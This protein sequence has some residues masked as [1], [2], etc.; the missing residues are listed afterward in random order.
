MNESPLRI[1]IFGTG[2][3]S[4]EVY[5]L[6]KQLNRNHAEPKFIVEGFVENDSS[7]LGKKVCDEVKVVTYDQLLEDYLGDFK[8][9]GIIIPIADSFIK[10]KIYTKLKPFNN[11]VFPNII[12]P[13]VI[14][15]EDIIEMTKGNIICA[16]TV[17][18][19]HLSLGSFNLINRNCTIGHDVRIG[20]YNT[21]NPMCAIS[22]DVTV[23]DNSLL[24]VGSIILQGL[25]IPSKVTIGAGAVLTTDAEFGKTYVGVP[26]KE[27]TKKELRD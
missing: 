9:I 25:R 3:A 20:N 6:I 2:G 15:E 4:R 16:G 12:H 1:I 17:I 10:E 5:Y 22:G 24:G 7:L 13:S 11:V 14:Y 27:L 8:R 19:S 23:N 26:A 21:I 18:G